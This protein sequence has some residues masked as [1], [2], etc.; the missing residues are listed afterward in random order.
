[1]QP[2]CNLTTISLQQLIFARFKK[3][4]DDSFRS[5]T[6]I[7]LPKRKF[8]ILNFRLFIAHF[9]IKRQQVQNNN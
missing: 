1:M 5:D 8:F 6:D 2:N 9:V 4:K 7:I 3:L